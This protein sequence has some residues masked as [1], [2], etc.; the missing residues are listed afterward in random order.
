MTTPEQQPSVDELWADAV[1]KHVAGLS[2]DEFAALVAR[3]RPAPKATSD[4]AADFFRELL[5]PQQGE[6]P[7]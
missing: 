2:E 5:N 3:T 1:A 7:E 6:Q 4:V